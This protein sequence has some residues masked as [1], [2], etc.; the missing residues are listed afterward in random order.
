MSKRMNSFMLFIGLFFMDL[1]YSSIIVFI[2]QLI[3]IDVLKMGDIPKYLT[4][5]LINISFMFIIYLI[6]R[7]E[8]NNE[9]KAFTQN[10]SKYFWF[11]FK[12][13]LVGLAL[14]ISS[15][16]AIQHFY[17]A[18]ASN[19][20]AVQNALQML[21]IYTA[22]SS[23][24]F[25]PFVEEMIFRKCLG[26]VFKSD[27]LFIIVSGF[28]FGFAHTLTS[29]SSDQLI[30]IIPYGLFGCIF[31]YMYRKTNNIFT[32]ITFHFIHNSILVF[33]SLLSLGVI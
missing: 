21:P 17:P 8:I 32:S 15:N 31:A 18:P 24:L 14:M 29:S 20:E 2:L 7:K 25:A 22:F 3:G 19:E 26:K 1:L 30:Y 5:I 9:F 6:Y 33:F 16:L 27:I 28:L 23:C 4:L 10:F 13:W 11:G 12:L